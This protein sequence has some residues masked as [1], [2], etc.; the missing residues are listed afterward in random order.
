MPLLFYSSSSRPTCFFLEF[1]VPTFSPHPKAMNPCPFDFSSS[2][3]C[4]FLSPMFCSLILKPLATVIISLF[5]P[6]TCSTSS[7]RTLQA[8]LTS[9]EPHQYVVGFRAQFER[10]T[11]LRVHLLL[12]VFLCFPSGA[13]QLPALLSKYSGHVFDREPRQIVVRTTAM[14]PVVRPTVKCCWKKGQRCEKLGSET[15][16]NVSF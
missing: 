8:L 2:L 6:S 9:A 10:L 14:L 15:N 7:V 4:S 12:D 11:I 1:F 5:N 3:P 13:R 16:E